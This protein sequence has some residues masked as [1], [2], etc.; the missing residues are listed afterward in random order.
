MKNY[1]CIDQSDRRTKPLFLGL[2]SRLY[3]EDCPQDLSTEKQLLNGKHP[4]S[5]DVEIFPFVVINP[6]GIALCRCLLTYYP[7]DPTAYVGFFEARPEIDAVRELFRRVEEKALSDGKTTLLGPIDVS[8]YINYRFKTNLFDRTYTSEPYNKDYYPDLWEKCG[9]S[10]R[11]RYVSNQ[12]RKVNADDIDPRLQKIHDRY[13]ARGYAFTSPTKQNFKQCLGDVYEAMMRLYSDFSGFKPISRSQYM[14]LF[15]PLEK[16]L[17]FD[18]VKLVYQNGQLCAF[19][20]AIPNYRYL[21][22]GKR[23]L[24]KLLGIMRTKRAPDEYVV[25]YMGAD[26]SVSGLGG[27]LAHCMRNAFYQLQCTSIGALIKEG[28]VTG[29]MYDSLYTDQFQYVLLCKE[30]TAQKESVC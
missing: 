7:H 24:R 9:F 16:A 25:L 13:I 4:L 19:S 21:T 2:P 27:S 18:M 22:R 5:T 11:D 1:L 28:Q 30:I 23:T 3:G 20:V 8:I 15:M 29:Q 6:C 14:K 17:N 12:L 10:V 26:R